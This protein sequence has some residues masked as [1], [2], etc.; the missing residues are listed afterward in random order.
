MHAYLWNAKGS[1]LCMQP[2]IQ[3]IYGKCIPPT[4]KPLGIERLDG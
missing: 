2:L 3:E 4:E 1:E